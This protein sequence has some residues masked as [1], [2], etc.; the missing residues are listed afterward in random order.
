MRNKKKKAL[1]LSVE[2]RTLQQQSLRE[3]D[4]QSALGM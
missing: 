3:Q 4:Q 2:E 1:I